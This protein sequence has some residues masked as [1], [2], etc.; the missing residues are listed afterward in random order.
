MLS[1]KIRQVLR[2]KQEQLQGAFK[3]CNYLLNPAAIIFSTY[4]SAFALFNVQLMLR[5]FV[6]HLNPPAPSVSVLSSCASSSLLQISNDKGKSINKQLSSHEVA[7]QSHICG[8][9]L[10][11]PTLPTTDDRLCSIKYES[12]FGTL[13]LP[14]SSSSWLNR[15]TLV[16]CA[17]TVVGDGGLFVQL[18]QNGVEWDV[19]S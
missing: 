10:L 3:V 4:Y 13:F 2:H 7:Y 18:C 9:R 16:R 15:S 1:R 11:S 5:T 19:E 17:F 8:R 6:L 14:S 12:F